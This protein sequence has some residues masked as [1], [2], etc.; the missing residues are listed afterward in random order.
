MPGN[1]WYSK[2]RER[3]SLGELLHHLLH[4]WGLGLLSLSP[5]RG[6][7]AILKTNCKEKS[8]DAKPLNAGCANTAEYWLHT[9]PHMDEKQ[10]VNFTWPW[11]EPVFDR[12]FPSFAT[13]GYNSINCEESIGQIRNLLQVDYLV[14]APKLVVH[15][16]SA[17]IR[18]W[19]L[20][21]TKS[22]KYYKN[23]YFVV[24]LTCDWIMS[25][26]SA[27]AST[28]SGQLC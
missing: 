1:V 9:D 10:E 7:A 8:L 24:A 26:A 4:S 17:S 28:N 25:T 14:D 15:Y 3:C 11:G 23:D 12:F 16:S 22:V 27:S 2:I 18:N 6:N 13:S 20:W 21:P 5:C 19:K